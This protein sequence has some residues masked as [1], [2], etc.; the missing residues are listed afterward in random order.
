MV[1][2]LVAFLIQYA[3]NLDTRAIRLKLDELLP[4]TE[5]AGPL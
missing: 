4:A 2:F 1:T 5:G 3:Q